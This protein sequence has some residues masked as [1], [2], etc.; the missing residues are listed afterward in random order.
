[1]NVICHI[2]RV[3]QC[4]YSAILRVYLRRRD[5]QAISLKNDCYTHSTK[6]RLCVVQRDH[7]RCRSCGQCGDEITLD[8]WQIHP[9][10]TTP[11]DM[12]TLCI[13][14]RSLVEARSITAI[15]VPDFLGHLWSQLQFPSR[16]EDS[17]AISA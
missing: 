8:V 5:A 9:L 14:C 17:I 10:N 16:P 1:M 11:E 6:V 4:A 7:C 3:A 13:R 12:V 15:D 2:H